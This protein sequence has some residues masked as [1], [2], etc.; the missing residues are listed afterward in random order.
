MGAGLLITRALYTYIFRVIY[1]QFR[2]IY[3]YI[4]GHH[5]L[6]VCF[7]FIIYK[8]TDRTSYCGENIS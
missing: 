4:Q 7:G 2:V 8:R 1:I 6:L 3:T 5:C